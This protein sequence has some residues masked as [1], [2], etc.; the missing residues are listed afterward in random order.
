MVL[1]LAGDDFEEDD[2][3]LAPEEFEE[4]M[5]RYALY[6]KFIGKMIIDM[7]K[8]IQCT[9]I[10]T[11]PRNEAKIA[12]PVFCCC[13]Y[14]DFVHKLL[15]CFISSSKPYNL[16]FAGYFT[17]D[18]QAPDLPF[19]SSNEKTY[20]KATVSVYI[21]LLFSKDACSLSIFDFTATSV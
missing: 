4:G 16:L 1:K 17:I 13:K 15:K 11:E 19:T 8:G 7:Y 3:D 20:F 10:L 2:L 21:F 9:A 18:P 5:E 14:A 6:A 12:F